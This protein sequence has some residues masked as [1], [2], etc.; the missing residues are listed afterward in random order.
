MTQITFRPIKSMKIIDGKYKGHYGFIC[1]P[2]NQ[3]P[4]HRKVWL[5]TNGDLITFEEIIH[6]EH[7][8]EEEHTVAKVMLL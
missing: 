7:V 2:L 4:T 5:T 1:T 6:M 3:H 8:S